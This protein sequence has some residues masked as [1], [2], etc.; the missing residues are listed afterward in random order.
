VGAPRHSHRSPAVVILTG[1]RVAT[2][3]AR[4]LRVVTAVM[5]PDELLPAAFDCPRQILDKGPLAVRLA[6]LVIRTGIDADQRTGC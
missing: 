3:E 5:P 1:R 6:K 2:D 4:R